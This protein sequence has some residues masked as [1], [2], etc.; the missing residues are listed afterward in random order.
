LSHFTAFFDACVLYPA[1]LRD[2][3]VEVAAR[4]I[5]RAKWSNLVHEEWIGNVLKN[6]PALTPERLERTRN[7][8]NESVRD[9]LVTDF[10]PLINALDLPDPDDRHVLAAAIKGRADVIVTFNL[11]DFPADKLDHWGIEAQHPD[12][13]LNH[14]FQ[15]AQPAF[16]ASVQTIRLRL[17]NPPKSVDEYLGSL[18]GCGLLETVNAIGRK[19]N[20]CA[21]C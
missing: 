7:L 16:L 14:Q 19:F 17:K 18:R 12:E 21:C 9:A 10:E 2:L 8:M 6:Q 15:L 4:G 13:F 3:L 11:K 20:A 5:Y 1:S